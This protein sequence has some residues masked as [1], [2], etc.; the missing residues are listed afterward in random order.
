MAR[1]ESG[2]TVSEASARRVHNG[3]GSSSRSVV[4]AHGMYDGAVAEIMK[5]RSKI[6]HHVCLPTCVWRHHASP[7][8]IWVDILFQRGQDARCSAKHRLR[9]AQTPRNIRAIVTRRC[10]AF[11][12]K[13]RQ[14]GKP[15]NGLTKGHRKKRSRECMVGY[16]AIWTPAYSFP[17]RVAPPRMSDCQSCYLAQRLHG[18]CL[19]SVVFSE[20]RMSSRWL[21]ARR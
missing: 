8:K 18:L 3:S 2:R 12:D 17:A 16:V 20:A 15:Y 19:A 6:T 14:T 1:T 4:L 7:R 9:L 11:R 5:K 10:N 21:W 13:T